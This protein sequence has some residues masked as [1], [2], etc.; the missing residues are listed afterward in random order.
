MS[1]AHGQGQVAQVARWLATLKASDACASW[2]AGERKS[3]LNPARK[4][5]PRSGKIAAVSGQEQRNF[6]ANQDGRSWRA[7]L[8]A[9]A[10]RF[11]FRLQIY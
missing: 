10:I 5:P 7:Q 2:T 4:T 11:Q 6:I 8:N 3:R 9:P 1:D